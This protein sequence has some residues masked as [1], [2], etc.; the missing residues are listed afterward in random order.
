MEPPPGD[1]GSPE[2]PPAHRQRGSPA[3]PPM[4]AHAVHNQPEHRRARELRAARAQD[5]ASDESDGALTPPK[6]RALPPVP[7]PRAAPAADRL[8]AENAMLTAALENARTTIADAAAERDE[9]RRR[10]TEEISAMR[11]SLNSARSVSRE[12]R[13]ALISS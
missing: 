2:P 3:P 5:D 11:A 4:P 6:P 12:A 1:P 7:S 13:M 8:A 9:L 10:A